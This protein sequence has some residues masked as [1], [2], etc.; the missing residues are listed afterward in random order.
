MKLPAQ[1]HTPRDGRCAVTQKWTLLTSAVSWR[2]AGVDVTKEAG[3]L[4]APNQVHAIGR[5]AADSDIIR[6]LVFI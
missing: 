3:A 6:T 2:T 5:T 1:H 4:V